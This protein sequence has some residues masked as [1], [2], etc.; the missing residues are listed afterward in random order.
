MVTL[1]ILLSLLFCLSNSQ[2]KVLE[3]TELAKQFRGK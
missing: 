1:F 3:P 2:I